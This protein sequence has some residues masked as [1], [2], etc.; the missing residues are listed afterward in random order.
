MVESSSIVV[1]SISK[2]GGKEGYRARKD[3]SSSSSRSRNL[4]LSTMKGIQFVYSDRGA[5]RSKDVPWNC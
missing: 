4:R 5:E 1:E 2:R 3:E